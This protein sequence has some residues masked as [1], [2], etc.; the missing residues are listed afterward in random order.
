MLDDVFIAHP[1]FFGV[2]SK[3]SAGAALSQ[4]IPALV[5]SDFYF[6]HAGTLSFVE[7]APF[8]LFHEL[9]FF[10][11]QFVNAIQN[12][13]IVHSLLLAPGDD[14]FVALW[15]AY[16]GEKTC[17]LLHLLYCNSPMRLAIGEFTR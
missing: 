2:E 14:V 9:M 13:A 6:V 8:F 17:T 4:E 5:Q 1:G 16:S 7:L 15:V 11:D 10:F 12:L 3:F